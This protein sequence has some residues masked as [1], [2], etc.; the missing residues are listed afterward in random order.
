MCVK[1]RL[2]I[3]MTWLLDVGGL[4]DSVTLLCNGVGTK[5]EKIYTRLNFFAIYHMYVLYE[6][7]ILIGKILIV[8]RK[9]NRCWYNRL[10]VGCLSICKF[11]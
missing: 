3:F 5:L 2:F 9:I 4:W 8:A 1:E 10:L 6:M 11:K 7:R